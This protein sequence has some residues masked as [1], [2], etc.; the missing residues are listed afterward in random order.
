MTE[1][2]V[3]FIYNINSLTRIDIFNHIDDIL[4]MRC[5][6]KNCVTINSEPTMARSHGL[7]DAH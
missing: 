6:L 7:M 4:D 1:E 2:A 3:R 5:Y